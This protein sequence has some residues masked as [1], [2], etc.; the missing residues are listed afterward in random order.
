M[1]KLSDA[2]ERRVQMYGIQ[3]PFVNAKHVRPTRGQQYAILVEAWRRL[4]P[5]PVK[6]VDAGSLLSL[7][8]QHSFGDV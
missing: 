6:R 4:L 2:L 3:A 1:S 7:I 5:G 8:Q